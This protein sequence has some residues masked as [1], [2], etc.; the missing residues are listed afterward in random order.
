MSVNLSGII[1]DGATGLPIEG[2]VVEV[3]ETSGGGL[4]ATDTTGSDGTYAFDLEPATVDLTVTAAGYVDGSSAAYGFHI[5]L[6]SDP[7]VANIALT[8]TPPSPSAVTGYS[9]GDASL[10]PGRATAWQRPAFVS[11]L[12]LLSD[13]TGVVSETLQSGSL[14]ARSATW[15]LPWVEDAEL[16]TLKGYLDSVA[17]VTVVTPAETV[18]AVVFDLPPAEF[19]GAG[20]WAI[21]GVVLVETG[22]SGGGGGGGT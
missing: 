21:S 16:A 17:Q 19:I 7:Q 2:A 12:P 6:V 10:W 14:P 22:E 13:G 5:D 8:V 11:R 4:L 3:L 20:L 18:T 15:D 9:I 1:T